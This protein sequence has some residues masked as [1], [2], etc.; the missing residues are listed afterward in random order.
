MD[1]SIRLDVEQKL[2]NGHLRAVVLFEPGD[3]DRH[4]VGGLRRAG[5]VPRF[6]S[7]PPED[8]SRRSPGRGVPGPL[9]TSSHDLLELVALQTGILR[10]SM[11]MLKFPENALDVLAQYLIGLTIVKEWDI[12]EGVRVVR[13]SGPQEPALRRLHRGPGPAGRGAQD[14]DRLGGEHDRE[15]GYAQMIY[16]TNIGTIA[17]DNNY[18]VFSSDGTM[19]GQLSSSFVSASGGA[20]SSSLGG[21]PT[22]CQHHRH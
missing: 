8:R 20:T 15:E 2:K 17:P 7:G 12:D 6:N 10:G 5:R 11:D 13:S 3:G 4:R 19:V 9:P 1:K 14:M 18:L 22:A 21:R 16:Y